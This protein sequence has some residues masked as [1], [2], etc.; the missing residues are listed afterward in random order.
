MDLHHNHRRRAG[1]AHPGT[2]SLFKLTLA[3]ATLG[4]AT[5]AEAQRPST[6]PAPARGVAAMDVAGV[7]LGM[8]REA[9]QAAATAASYRCERFGN[10][11][12]FEEQVGR[13]VSERRGEK[14]PFFGP[15]SG[16]M[17]LNCTGPAGESL[18][19][20]F[21]QVGTGDVVDNIVF[22]A[23]P[24]RVDQT[25]M[26]RQVAAK[27]GTPTVGNAAY[28][29]WCDAGRRCDTLFATSQGDLPKFAVDTRTGLQ[30]GAS[31][32]ALAERADEAAVQAEA[33]RRAPARDRAAF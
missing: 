28:G 26:R 22:R 32:G 29:T 17:Q 16:T 31:R 30:I 19:V 12:S 24:G 2:P 25:A 8:G 23:D 33:A 6:S 13:L 5:G 11:P 21:A 4:V 10:T 7:R 18:R 1:T 9:A 15:R 14:V 3:L 20:D 27:Y